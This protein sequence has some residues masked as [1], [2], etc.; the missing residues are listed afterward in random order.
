MNPHLNPHDDD[1]EYLTATGQVFSFGMNWDGQLGD[2]SNTAS[3]IPVAVYS[4]GVLNGHIITA[5]AA[6]GYHSIVLSG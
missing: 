4:S 2:N 5:I 3:N 6:R 1:D